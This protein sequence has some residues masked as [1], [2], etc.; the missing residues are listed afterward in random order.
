[1][2]IFDFLLKLQR[3]L[4]NQHPVVRLAAVLQEDGEDLPDIGQQ[5]VLV[6][7]MLKTLLDHL[8][9]PNAVHKQA[10]VNSVDLLLTDR[11]VE[12]S[13]AVDAVP[14]Q[15]KLMRWLHDQPGDF[16]VLC[17]RQGLIHPELDHVRAHLSTCR[18]HGISDNFRI[19]VRTYSQVK[20]FQYLPSSSPSASLFIVF[21][22]FRLNLV[23]WAP[24]S[25][26]MAPFR[27]PD[28]KEPNSGLVSS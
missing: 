10:A 28:A 4:S 22:L 25:A 12:E 5:S 6:G 23:L 3:N 8:V 15:R 13:S 24:F 16:Q 7:R 27:V 14:H 2:Y 9:E 19:I 1:M 21:A 20:A 17:L 26:S 11:L 18:F